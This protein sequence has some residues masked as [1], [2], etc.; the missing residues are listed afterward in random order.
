MLA[1]AFAAPA[2]ATAPQP[3]LRIELAWRAP[4]MLVITVENKFEDIR[5]D[6]TMSVTAGIGPRLVHEE[7]ITV[8]PGI[9]ERTIRV[10]IVD[11]VEEI[12][13]RI[14]GNDDRGLL[15]VERMHVTRERALTQEEV[16]Q[17]YA[18]QRAVVHARAADETRARMRAHVRRVLARGGKPTCSEESAAD[19]NEAVVAELGDSAP[20]VCRELVLR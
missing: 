18:A 9:T 13:V 15:L 10:P 12:G 4:E 5:F 14:T 20:S 2:M 3:M 19:C 17:R 1:L 7:P 6:A 11:D 16:E 8:V